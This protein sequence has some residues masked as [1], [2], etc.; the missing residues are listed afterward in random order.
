VVRGLVARQALGEIDEAQRLVERAAKR[1]ELGE[2]LQLLSSL[3]DIGRRIAA[4]I[5]VRY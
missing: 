2:G 4:K 1:M 5:G 3:E